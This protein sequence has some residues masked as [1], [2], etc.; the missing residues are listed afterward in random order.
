MGAIMNRNRFTHNRLH[1]GHGVSIGSAT[2]AGAENILVAN[3]VMDGAS[4]LN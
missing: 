1:Q 2:N 3:F 4:A